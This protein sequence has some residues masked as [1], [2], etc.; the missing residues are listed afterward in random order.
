MV[1]AMLLLAVVL[2]SH[3]TVA[4]SAASSPAYATLAHS[5]ANQRLQ[6]MKF[7]PLPLFGNSPEKLRALK[8]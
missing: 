4:A 5:P 8:K 1:S 2:I 6:L 7:R 3:G